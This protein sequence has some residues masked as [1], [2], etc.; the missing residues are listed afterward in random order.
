VSISSQSETSLSQIYQRA[1]AL[2][3]EQESHP[4]EARALYVALADVLGD[5]AGPEAGSDRQAKGL[6][7]RVR[8]AVI[9]ALRRQALAARDAWVKQGSGDGLQVA[10]NLAEDALRLHRPDD[11]GRGETEYILRFLRATEAVAAAPA[12]RPASLPAEQSALPA[13]APPVVLPPASAPPPVEPAASA[14]APAPGAAGKEPARDREA[15]KPAAPVVPAAPATPAVPSAPPE[16]PTVP[17][18]PAEVVVFP[19]PGSVPEVLS[20]AAPPAAPAAARPAAARPAERPAT[21]TGRRSALVPILAVIAVLGFVAGVLTAPRLMGTRRAEKVPTV[22]V[23]P[24]AAVPRAAPTA[25]PVA[26]PIQ[27]APASAPSPA[28]PAAPAGSVVPPTAAPA[29]AP[30]R[31]SASPAPATVAVVLRSDPSGAKVYVGGVLRGVTPLRLEST[32]GNAIRVTV[33][34][35]N[36]LWRGTLRVGTATSQTVTVRLPLPPVP[37]AQP[38]PTSPPTPVATPTVDRR[39][40]YQSLLLQGVELYRS[41]W[42]GPAAARFRQATTV[43]PADPRAYLWLARASYRAG[44]YAEARRALEKVI[45]MAPGSES[46]REAQKLL[47][48]LKHLEKGT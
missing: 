17:E 4:G 25:V 5:Q 35:G 19:A 45:A 16:R 39:T 40:H 3:A 20:T 2:A 26:S 6:P 41:G 18:K 13:G 22:V 24:S 15:A 14:P 44:R 7:E 42:Y 46:A 38:A 37:V 48:L 34:R 27:S 31:G 23:A 36:R 21:R 8:R 43:L 10:V 1:R 33:R 28:R 9:A 32:P 11:T 47:N 12:R 29:A 30:P